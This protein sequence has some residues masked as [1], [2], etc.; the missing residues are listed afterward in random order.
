M[1]DD[2]LVVEISGKR[3]GGLKERPT[4]KMDTS[5]KMIIISNNS[6]NYDTKLQIINVPDEYR[7]WYCD[8][9]K[10]SDNAW[11]AP[12][13]RSYA[14]KYAKEHG[15]RYLVQLDDNI[16]FL[17]ISFFKEEN[18][19]NKRYRS[20]KIKGI[21]D[22]YIDVFKAVLKNT[23][24]AMVGGQLAGLG[25][26]EWKYLREGY[27]YSI[28]MVDVERCPSVFHGD[29]EDDV[30]FRLKCKQMNVPVIQVPC[31]RY[32]KTGQAHSKDNS[33]CRAE[34][35]KAGLK[36]GE[37]MRKLYSDMYDCR[38]TK[39][40]KTASKKTD[41]EAPVNFKHILKPFNVGV[42]IND[43][44]EIKKAI[45]KALEHQ[46][47]FRPDDTILKT[48]YKKAE[49]PQKERGNH[50]ENVNAGASE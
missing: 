31:L 17:E 26:P 44:E 48:K 1:T 4:E 30:E 23:N 5:H 49:K 43:G 37:H 39:S 16:K 21:L 12:M 38:M 9:I 7:K 18:G 32:S 14:I 35:L 33:G 11:Y 22:D 13:N 50:E 24:A 42:I 2:V 10:N 36:R 47:V 29:F 19:I 3:P 41:S 45:Y 15:Y 34:Y 25:E 20:Q 46:F 27:C 6:E 8:N 28:F 40:R